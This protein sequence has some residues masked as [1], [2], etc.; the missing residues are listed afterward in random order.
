MAVRFWGNV[1]AKAALKA[2]SLARFDQKACIDKGRAKR[3]VLAG[4]NRYNRKER[5]LSRIFFG[6]RQRELDR[7]EE[8]EHGDQRDTKI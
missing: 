2:K 1:L 6:E 7:L 8:I 4:K 3:L 5:R